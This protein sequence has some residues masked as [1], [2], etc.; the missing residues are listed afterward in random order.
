M[1]Q[2]EAGTS[3]TLMS[4][5]SQLGLKEVQS[6]VQGCLA[7]AGPEL[8]PGSFFLQGS[9]TLHSTASPST[10][11]NQ[12]ELFHVVLHCPG[13]CVSVPSSKTIGNKNLPAETVT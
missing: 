11:H 10:F 1:R 7:G 4:Q 8:G 12:G 5:M 2:Y 3:S 9:E 6:L 13:S